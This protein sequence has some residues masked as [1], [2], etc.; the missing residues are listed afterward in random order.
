MPANSSAASMAPSATPVC[1][2]YLQNLY[3]VTPQQSLA[4]GHPVYEIAHSG[5]S[6]V[7]RGFSVTKFVTEH[8]LINLDTA[9]S[10]IR[11]SPSRSPLVESKDAARSR[12]QST[13][14]SSSRGGSSRRREFGGCRLRHACNRLSYARHTADNNG[15]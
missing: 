11:G 9:I 12:A 4:S 8:W 5:T 15:K 2:H 6:A 14:N 3:G 1:I 13:I 10:Q 7:G